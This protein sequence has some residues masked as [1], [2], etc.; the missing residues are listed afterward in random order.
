MSSSTGLDTL[1]GCICLRTY[2]RLIQSTQTAAE[3]L[4]MAVAITMTTLEV[5]QLLKSENSHS[6]NFLQFP[7]FY[8]TCSYVATRTATHAATHSVIAI[9][10]LRLI[11]IMH[12]SQIIALSGTLHTAVMQCHAEE[13][14]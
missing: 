6:A 8:T 10:N 7:L 1:P 14:L 2:I 11:I 13:I 4:T 5:G 12:L 3:G 9:S